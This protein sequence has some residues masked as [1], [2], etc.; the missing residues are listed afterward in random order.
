METAKARILASLK[1]A[2]PKGSTNV[3]LSA[4]QLRYGGSTHELQKEGYDITITR[5]EGGLFLYV[6]DMSKSTTEGL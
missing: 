4:I 3:E 2:G 6:L 1:A 5:V